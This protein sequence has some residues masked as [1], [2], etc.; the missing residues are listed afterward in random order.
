[1]TERQLDTHDEMVQSELTLERHTLRA[2]AVAAQLLPFKVIPEVETW[3]LQHI[4]A[5]SASASRFKI[6]VLEG[7]SRFGKT[8]YA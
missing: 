2:S 3:M 7:D 4:A 5:E 1:M 8:R 6:L